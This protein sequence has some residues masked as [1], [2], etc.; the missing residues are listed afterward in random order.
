MQYR[1]PAQLGMLALAFAALLS[2]D[3]SAYALTDFV[4]IEGAVHLGDWGTQQQ[5]CETVLRPVDSKQIAVTIT[6][7]TAV[8]YSYVLS[9]NMLLGSISTSIPVLGDPNLG[10]SVNYMWGDSPGVQGYDSSGAPWA[11]GG[12]GE[13]LPDPAIVTDNGQFWAGI[14]QGA[15]FGSQTYSGNPALPGKMLVT[16]IVSLDDKIKN[17]PVGTR[18]YNMGGLVISK[19]RP[20]N[21]SV[22]LNVPSSV[23][24]GVALIGTYTARDLTYSIASPSGDA[25]IALYY[26]AE[27]HVPGAP[28]KALLGDGFYFVKNEAGEYYVTTGNEPYRLRVGAIP[29]V[30]RDTVELEVPLTATPGEKIANLTIIAKYD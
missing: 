13:R 1:V 2:P 6:C 29:K 22:E 7:D 10:I 30:I 3:A 9:R 4:T 11:T 18:L 15:G 14:V 16:A 20:V 28:R 25:S 12:F 19:I 21:A 5:R 26:R 24:F 23:D 27:S 8:R 17:H